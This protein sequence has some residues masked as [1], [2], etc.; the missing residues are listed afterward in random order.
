MQIVISMHDSI[1]I[2]IQMWLPA[3]N[4]CEGEFA[5]TSLAIEKHNEWG[6]ILTQN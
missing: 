3:L 4:F 2:P 1:N 5:T 6:S